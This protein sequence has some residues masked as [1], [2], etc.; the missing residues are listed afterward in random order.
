MRKPSSLLLV[1]LLALRARA[2][3][4]LRAESQQ[5]LSPAVHE[6]AETDAPFVYI[7]PD[8]YDESMEQCH[9]RDKWTSY[10]QITHEL[11]N[12][13]HLSGFVTTSP[14]KARWFLFPFSFERSYFVGDCG[15]TTHV[16]RVMHM[17][18]VLAQSPWFQ[19]KGGRDHVIPLMAWMAGAGNL[20]CIAGP[21]KYY[22][23]I[24][25]GGMYPVAR[26]YLLH[27]VTMTRMMNYGIH[28]DSTQAHDDP[29]YGFKPTLLGTRTTYHGEVLNSMITCQ[30]YVATDLAYELD[31]LDQPFRCAWWAIGQD[32]RCTV[33]LPT[34]TTVDLPPPAD[35]SFEEWQRR[36]TLI[37]YRGH[38]RACQKDSDL[39]HLATMRHI[40]GMVPNSTI[41]YSHADGGFANYKAE[42]RASKFCLVLRCD[43]LHT[44][45]FEDSVAAG[46][47]PII[48]NDGFSL[49]VAPFSM[50]LNYASFTVSIPEGLWLADTIA[51][52]RY[53]YDVP[54]AI[55]RQRHANLIAAKP[56]LL[57]KSGTAQENVARQMWARADADCA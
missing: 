41:E 20:S 2:A 3:D 7:Y 17:T 38:G 24:E 30:G 39:V 33:V 27:N 34:I 46:C 16:Q 54:D 43:D 51:A 18:D 23:C 37:Y 15:N 44:S 12:L 50:A 31:P 49:E 14:E 11:I 32:W 19:R 29:H 36:P 42:L 21:M 47:I 5:H 4:T 25:P 9:S 22:S 35:E 56:K 8:P 13:T 1:A 6:S 48:I 40:K 57:W 53:I 10:E 45:R 28:L 26:R 52:A 55:N